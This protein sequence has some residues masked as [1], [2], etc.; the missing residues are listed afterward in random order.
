MG[1][2]EGQG[3][4]PTMDRSRRARM[5]LATGPGSGLAL[6]LERRLQGLE[7][8]GLSLRVRRGRLGNR[9]QKIHLGLFIAIRCIIS[10]RGGIIIRSGRRI[11]DVDNG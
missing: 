6:R 8:S 7:P 11:I 9:I 3:G 4:Q 1:D 5:D 10:M 2:T